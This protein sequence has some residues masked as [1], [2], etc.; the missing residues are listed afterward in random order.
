MR[1]TPAPA[2]QFA[3]ADGEAGDR[4]RG[5]VD[6]ADRLEPSVGRDAPSDA[7]SGGISTPAWSPDDQFVAF[8]GCH[9][10]LPDLIGAD[11][12]AVYVANPSTLKL[13]AVASLP[14]DTCNAEFRDCSASSAAWR[15]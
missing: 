3:L 13:R 6:R 1:R 12:C 10:K 15:G 11:H 9:A 14:D 4:G 5:D 8:V 2:R 7:L